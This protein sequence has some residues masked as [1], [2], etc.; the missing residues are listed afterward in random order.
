LPW[1]YD[2]AGNV[3]LASPP[4]EVRTFH[5]RPMVLEESIVTD[6]A[7]VRAAVADRAG[8]CVFHASARNFNPA[9]AMA[10]RLTVVEAER[11]VEVGEIGPDDVHLPGI[12]VQ[13]VVGL[14]PEQAARK[15]VEKRTTRPRES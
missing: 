10:G 3:V 12:F 8:N 4:K 13:R 5:G 1:R 15:D 14:T 11:L 7:L 6:V 2:T 9:A